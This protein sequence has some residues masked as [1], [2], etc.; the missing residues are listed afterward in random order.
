[1]IR[2]VCLHLASSLLLPAVI[3]FQLS[4]P[5]SGREVGGM[6]VPHRYVTSSDI[7]GRTIFHV[8]SVEVGVEL[9][10]D[11]FTLQPSTELGQGK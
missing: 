4:T 9:A 10:P 8:E 5:A 2:H 11:I 6:R 1:M 3:F 7:A